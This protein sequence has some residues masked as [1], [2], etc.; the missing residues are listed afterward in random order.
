MATIDTKK[1]I[2]T[3]LQITSGDTTQI[4]NK[5]TKSHEV[6]FVTAISIFRILPY[7]GMFTLHTIHA[8]VALLHKRRCFTALLVSAGEGIGGDPRA[9]ENARGAPTLPQSASAQ[10]TVVAPLSLQNRHP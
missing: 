1:S 2:G 6:S 9:L 4:F 8:R 7:Y 3:I 10:Q 5:S